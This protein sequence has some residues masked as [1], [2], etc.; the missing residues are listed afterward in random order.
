MIALDRAVLEVQRLR[1]LMMELGFKQSNPTPIYQ[2][3][4]STIIWAN[5]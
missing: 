5:E 3:N 2:D 1:Y 4:K